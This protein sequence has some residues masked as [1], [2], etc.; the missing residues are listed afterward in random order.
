MPEW[1]IA[2]LLE[3][4]S[5]ACAIHLWWKA[6]G[7]AVHKLSWMPVVLVPVAGPLFRARATNVGVS[8]APRKSR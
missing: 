7:S 3:V 2:A 4:P 6:R 5:V 8:N 1:A